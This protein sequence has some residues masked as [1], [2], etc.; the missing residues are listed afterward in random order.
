MQVGAVDIDEGSVEAGVHL[1]IEAQLVGRFAR[2][3]GTADEGIGAYPGFGQP[4]FQLKPAQNLRGIGA[5]DDA[6]ADT[7]EGRRL[8]WPHRA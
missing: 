3:P 2:V 5:E 1:G 6:G 7:R 4:A 8:G